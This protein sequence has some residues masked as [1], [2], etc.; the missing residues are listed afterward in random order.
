MKRINE[1]QNRIEQ[2]RKLDILLTSY[3]LNGCEIKSTDKVTYCGDDGIL[4]Y[5]LSETYDKHYLNKDVQ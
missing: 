1:I 5:K 2:S 3:I 4:F